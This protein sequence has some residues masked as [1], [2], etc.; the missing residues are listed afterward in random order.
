ME[1]EK[2]VC[3]RGT[4][5]RSYGRGAQG[6]GRDFGAV[7]RGRGRGVGAGS[8]VV[9]KPGGAATS[10]GCTEDRPKESQQLED[11]C[12]TQDTQTHSHC[13]SHPLAVWIPLA[14]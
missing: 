7:G 5:G 11:P 14:L 2:R 8:M 12:T 10:G 6:R 1:Q 13:E 3:G 4:Q 9:K